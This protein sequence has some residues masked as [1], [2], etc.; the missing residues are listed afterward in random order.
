MKPCKRPA[1]AGQVD[2]SL[3]YNRRAGIKGTRSQEVGGFGMC[4]LRYV[5]LTKTHLQHV[6][7]AT[8]M[9]LWRIVN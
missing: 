2:W 9:N 3:R 4:R 5:G 7:T 8:A 1:R 6:F